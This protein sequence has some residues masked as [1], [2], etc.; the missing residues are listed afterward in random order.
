[1]EI[2]GDLLARRKKLFDLLAEEPKAPKR[3]RVGPRIPPKSRHIFLGD[4]LCNEVIDVVAAE[5]GVSGGANDLE[6]APGKIEDGHVEGATTEV[7]NRNAFRPLHL[8]TVG[9][10]RCGRLIENAEDVQSRQ[11][12]RNLR[13]CAL[14]FVEV[15]RDGD[16]RLV[17]RFPKRELSNGLCA[18]QDK[19]GNFRKC[20]TLAARL[21]ENGVSGT[22]NGKRGRACWTSGVP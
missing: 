6:N 7:E 22:G 1:V 5:L 11:A 20:V 2:L 14:E 12:S 16:D 8:L 10:R 19:R 21:Y 17:D 4:L 3:D 13:R 9:E 18:P 15:R